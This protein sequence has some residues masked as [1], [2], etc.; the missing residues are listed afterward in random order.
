MLFIAAL[1]FAV[2]LFVIPG[3][4]LLEMTARMIASEGVWYLVVISLLNLAVYAIIVVL[5]RVT[6][7]AFIDLG[8]ERRL[9]PWLVIN[10]CQWVN[11]YGLVTISALA[12][13]LAVEG[14]LPFQ[15][16][17]LF[18]AIVVGLVDTLH[19]NRLFELPSQ[20]PTPLF[21]P[22]EIIDFGESESIKEMT[23]GW[24]TWADHLP[25]GGQFRAVFPLS[26]A[27]YT[28]HLGRDRRPT[29]PIKEYLHYV[30]EGLS[31]SVEAVA[32]W[33]RTTSRSHHFTALE[34]I[35]SIVN[36]TRSIAYEYDEQTRSMPDWADY[37]IELLY[38]GEG[39]CEDHALLASCLLHHL[40]HDVGVFW[41]LLEDSAHLALALCSNDVSGPF[42]ANAANGRLY[43]YVE[44]VPSSSLEQIGDLPPDFAADLQDHLVAAP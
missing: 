8:E 21:D 28:E 31:P 22:D 25:E 36:F 40:G 30:H 16:W 14:R 26:V 18:G 43:Y 23:F 2:L 32:A 6:R 20:L 7:F 12:V 1:I 15:F 3:E 27:E 19:K 37:P 24:A 13:W 5:L 17:F 10:G 11:V 42:F 35:D 44:T 9:R 34:E 39:D 29:Q 33:F 41:L 38:D 4:L